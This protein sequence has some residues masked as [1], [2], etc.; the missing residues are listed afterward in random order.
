[1]V[2]IGV[3]PTFETQPVIP[4]LEAHLLDF[5]GD[6]YGKNLSLDFV[7]FIRGE[8]PFKSPEL[9]KKQVEL[10][11][12]HAQKLLETASLNFIES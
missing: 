5:Q 4:R 10:D 11:K 1:M 9:L 2:N 12:H 6:L 7:A 8:Q 3:R